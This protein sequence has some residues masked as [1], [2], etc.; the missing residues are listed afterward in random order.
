MEKLSY[1]E[2]KVLFNKAKNGD[3]NSFKAIYEATYRAQ[4]YIAFDYINNETL[5]QEAVQNMYIA[6]YKHLKDIKNDVSIVKWMN[7]ATINECKHLIRKEKLNSKVNLDNYKEVFVDTT[8]NPE[9]LYKQ[10]DEKDTLTKALDKLDP[11][12]KELVVYRFVDNLKIKEIAE[13]TKLSTAT[14]N[15]YIAKATS[16]LKK[17]IE[18]INKNFY[19]FVF[20]P[21]LFKMFEETMKKQVSDEQILKAY[22]KLIEI[23]AKAGAAFVT[24]TTGSKIA[25]AAAKKTTSMAAKVAI[26]AGTTVA[27]TAVVV[28][29][30][31]SPNFKINLIDDDYVLNQV[32]AVTSDNVD[33]ISNI[34]C[35][36]GDN[37]IGNINKENDYSLV[38]EENGKY[39]IVVEDVVGKTQKED[40][41]INNI[42]FEPPSVNIEKE[43]D[44]FVATVNDTQSG[45]DFSKISIVNQDGQ[46]VDYTVEGN[47]I[48]FTNSNPSVTLIIPD[49]LGNIKNAIAKYTN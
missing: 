43:N 44:T 28:A 38:I 2:L 34:Y 6:F 48:I 22:S 32:I 15:R 33:Q 18:N 26:G 3:E 21:L 47:K 19:G 20:T 16:S 10:K 29:A 5:A 24:G 46:K 37:L 45:V 31:I 40:I 41:E 36:Q 13:I 27:T 23:I 7:V 1:D 35:Y 17:H 12:L 25:S 49:K 14:V 8:S 4:F 39:T 42:D 30:T 11:E 9:N